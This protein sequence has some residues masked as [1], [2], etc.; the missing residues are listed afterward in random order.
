MTYKNIYWYFCIL[1][2]VLGQPLLFIDFNTG[3]S[4]FLG[5]LAPAIMSYINIQLIERLSKEKGNLMAFGFNMMQFIVKSIFLCS[6]TYLGVKIIKLDFRIFVPL[7]C[8]T[9][10]CLLYTSPS[11][12]D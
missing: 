5:M 2:F 9:W 3:A 7:L 10:F 8:L 6:L 11:P 4:I 1:I 12:R